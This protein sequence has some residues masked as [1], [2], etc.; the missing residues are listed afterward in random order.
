MTEG[1][2]LNPTFSIL[3]VD[4]DDV[5]TEFVLRSLRK[6]HVPGKWITASSGEEALAILR[7]QHGEKQVLWPCIILL[8]LNMP[9]MDGF[10]FLKIL[11][12]DPALRHTV[13][14][15]LTTSSRDI[16]RGR[17]Y[18]E[19]IAGYMV[20]STIGPQFAELSKL[21]VQYTSTVILP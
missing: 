14:F 3:I 5:A 2:P 17:A 21:L 9:Q 15:V 7:G 8:D 10:G 11:R 18:E 20:K 19:H 12:E 6:N 13:V 1:T 16:D 4:D